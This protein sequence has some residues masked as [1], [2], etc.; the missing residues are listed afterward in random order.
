MVEIDEQDVPVSAFFVG[1]ATVVR[2]RIFRSRGLFLN[3]TGNPDYDILCIE[4]N[5]L[6]S[7]P[8]ALWS[9]RNFIE[10]LPGEWDEVSLPGLAENCFPGTCLDQ[11]VSP[12]KVV[13]DKVV[14]SPFVDLDLVRQKDGDYLSLLSSHTR[15]YLKRSYR[16]CEKKGKIS[17]EVAPDEET[18]LKI[19]AEMVEL[20]QKRW[21][22]KGQ[23]GAFSSRFMIDFHKRL[24]IRRFQKGEIQLLRVVSNHV[25]LGCLYN[26]V[27]EGRVYC[28][29]TGFN[30]EVDRRIS[31]GLICHV[32]A[33]QH[34]AR[35]GHSVY[36]FLG[37]E[38]LYKSRLSTGETRLIYARIQRPRFR[39]WLEAQLKGIKRSLRRSEKMLKTTEIRERA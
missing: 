32:E 28:Y 27:H 37:G 8:A 13:I 33:I 23:P 10:A 18:A 22:E 36:D 31:P 24:I 14:P 12:C 15:G 3:S 20:H 7:K 6:L 21:T 17:V 38:N 9:L 39:F 1:R 19:F 35:L 5:A 4:Y 29:Q 26:L 25:T 30:F 16:D 11:I 2:N 34:N